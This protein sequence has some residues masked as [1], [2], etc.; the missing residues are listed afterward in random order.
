MHVL[1]NVVI[2]CKMKQGKCSAAAGADKG[3]EKE[4]HDVPPGAQ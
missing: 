4:K 1:V 2:D 3:S